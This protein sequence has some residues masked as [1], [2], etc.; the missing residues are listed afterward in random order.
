MNCFEEIKLVFRIKFVFETIFK[1]VFKTV[2]KTT[3]QTVFKTV[4]KTVLKT[5]FEK[6][7]KIAN[8]NM[9]FLKSIDPKKR[10]F[11]VM[12]FLKQGRTSNK[13]FYQN[14]QVT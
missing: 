10:D 1:T 13:T 4:S 14:L 3:F 9:S 11:I 2:F 12:S 5:V 8:K 7:K 6:I